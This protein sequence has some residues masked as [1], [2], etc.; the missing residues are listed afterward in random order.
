MNFRDLIRM[1]LQ[2]LWVR[3]SSTAF[4]I[5]GIVVSCSMLLL[6]FAGTR[7]ARDGLL[8]L[9]SESELA[10]QFAIRPGRNL[11]V[12]PKAAPSQKNMPQ[13]GIAENRKERIR[14]QLDKDWQNKN[15]PLTRLTLDKL[16]ELR[17][18]KDIASVMPIRSMPLQLT[19]DDRKIPARVVCTS[20]ND[21]R[22]AERIV[23]GAAP[24]AT[25]VGEIWIDEY[26]AYRLG[27][28]TDEQL[29]NLIG[30]PVRLRFQVA[31]ATLSPSIRRFAAAFGI[32]GI[33]E[34]EQLAETFSKLL[35]DL[36][37]TD[38][39][40]IEK[41]TLRLAAGRLGL[42]SPTDIATSKKGQPFVYRDFK[43]AGIVQPP[44]KSA[45]TLFRITNSSRSN[46]LIMHWRDYQ[47]IEQAT[48]PKRIYNYCVGSV[49]NATDLK[50]VINTVEASGFETRSAVEIIDK[51]DEQLGRV[52]LIVGAIAV[53]ILLI[54]CVGIMNSVIIAVI[55]RTPE[56][57][58]MKA[59]GATDSDIR[60]LMLV[61][62]FLTGLV[63]A[64]VSVGFAFLI[65]AA[66]SQYA[67][68]VIETKIDRAFDFRIFVYS[69]GDILLISSIAIGVSM[70]A[71]LLPSRRA[72]KLDPVVAM[73]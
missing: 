29:K 60:N 59:I 56:F 62:A 40:D 21:R 23:Y 5:F 47:A 58:I 6:V 45:S 46:D 69:T 73:K 67:R 57:G 13:Q 10:K 11:N 24:S 37:Q 8:N 25:S 66:T 7:G 52:R 53:V 1:A 2:N 39:D 17:A 49:E 70:L 72:A 34:T 51:A 50:T 28:R 42:D 27:F 64:M 63:G 41:E 61:E 31:S 15:Y 9:F 36:D 4:N 38:L 14:L 32:S 19:I 43:I 18:T 26:R 44:S 3:R 65:D 71:S 54:A 55:Q 33:N 20:D 30:Q 48:Q 22:F 35:S 68:Q 16:S 12:S